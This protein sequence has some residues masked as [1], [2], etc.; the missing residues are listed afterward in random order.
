MVKRLSIEDKLHLIKRAEASEKVSEICRQAGI[1]RAL[2][3]R[4]RKR[5]YSSGKNPG[6]LK[7]RKPQL[8]YKRVSGF[9]QNLILSIVRRYPEY[10]SKKISSLLPKKI[11]GK[12]VV[13]NHGVAN[14]LLRLGL[15]TYK[16]RLKYIRGEKTLS[17]TSEGEGG[18]HFKLI[19]ESRLAIIR[20]VE[21]GAKVSAICKEYG[22]SRTLFYRLLK[23]Y[24]Q[25]SEEG[26]L[27]ALSD[28]LPIPNHFARL[29]PGEIEKKVLEIVAECPQLSIHKIV[30]VL[31]QV[32]G[33]PIL[34]N[35]G[36]QNVLARHNLGTYEQRLEYSKLTEPAWKPILAIS[37]IPQIPLQVWRMLYT[38]T[39]GETEIEIIAFVLDIMDHDK[40]NKKFGY[41]KK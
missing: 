36:V 3:Y 14:V 8:I 9:N 5:F 4:I 35:K 32:A 1:S 34:S 22:I 17:E 19:P 18:R 24:K 37:E 38:L 28:R 2:F 13:G 10:S 30:E 39:N 29:T 40:Y 16:E 15:P 25:A 20:R 41:K 21:A 7:P 33:R 11:N 26:K 31:P 27:A 12:P 23:R 6:S